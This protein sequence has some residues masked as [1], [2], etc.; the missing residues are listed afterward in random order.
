MSEGNAIAHH[1]K[2]ILFVCTANI[3]RSPMAEAIFNALAEDRG[4]GFRAESVGVRA[5]KGEPMA[6]NAR[7]ALEEV[8]IYVKNHR[9]RQASEATLEGGAL[10]LAMSPRHVAELHRIFGDS[11]EV[12]TLPTYVN[13]DSGDEGVADPYGSTMTAYRACARQLL[14]YVELLLDRLERQEALL[15]GS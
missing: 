14:E 1:P 5:L 8:G 4:L 3:C 9:A 11:F 2:K 10:V 7:A 12:H 13:S 6:P 15:A